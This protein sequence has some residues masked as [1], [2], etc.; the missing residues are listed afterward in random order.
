MSKIAIPNT[1]PDVSK[2]LDT[3]T[4]DPEAGKRISLQ[5]LEQIAAERRENIGWVAM[6]ELNRRAPMRAQQVIAGSVTQ[7]T[8]NEYL[9]R[10]MEDNEPMRKML[11]LGIAKCF[12]ETSDSGL[13]QIILQE[14]CNQYG[15]TGEEAEQVATGQIGLRELLYPFLLRPVPED[16]GEFHIQELVN[17]PDDN[18]TAG[19]VTGWLY[20]K[21]G[22]LSH[23]AIAGHANEPIC[24]QISASL[25][26]A[27]LEYPG[28][29]PDEALLVPGAFLLPVSRM[30]GKEFSQSIVELT[31]QLA[32]LQEATGLVTVHQANDSG[33]E[34][35]KEK[36]K[37]KIERTRKSGQPTLIWHQTSERKG[38]LVYTPFYRLKDARMTPL[39]FELELSIFNSEEFGKLLDAQRLELRHELVRDA[40]RRKHIYEEWKERDTA[41]LHQMARDGFEKL[42]KKGNFKQTIA[43]AEEYVGL[44]LK[45]QPENPPEFWM[46][47]PPQVRSMLIAG[48]TQRL[49]NF[50]ENKLHQLLANDEAWT[51]MVKP[52][53]SRDLPVQGRRNYEDATVGDSDELSY[54]SRQEA[55]EWNL[56]SLIRADEHFIAE[57]D[58]LLKK[59]D[60]K[61]PQR[62]KR[63]DELNLYTL[64]DAFLRNWPPV[65]L[66]DRDAREL[67]K[68]WSE[69]LS[70]V[71]WQEIYE[72][73][74][75]LSIRIDPLQSENIVFSIRG[76]GTRD[77]KLRIT[78]YYLTT[79]REMMILIHPRMGI[80]Y[81]INGWQHRQP[82]KQAHVP[83]GK[84]RTA[85][86]KE[87]CRKGREKLDQADVSHAIE[88][89]Q[90]ALCLQPAV[91]AMELF[92]HF[93][94]ATSTKTS[95]EMKEYLDL[96]QAT[97]E[98]DK[99]REAAL[100]KINHFVTIYPNFL[101]DPY[102][103]RGYNQAE[104]R[105]SVPKL[106]RQFE[107][108]VEHYNSLINRL[109]SM[110]D[111]YNAQA[112]DLINMQQRH[113]ALLEELIKDE[114]LIRDRN[115]QY[116]VDPDAAYRSNR[117]IASP[118]DDQ[119]QVELNDDF[120]F[121]GGWLNKSFSKNKLEE[122]LYLQAAIEAEQEINGPEL[123]KK[124]DELDQMAK[125]LEPLHQRITERREAWQEECSKVWNKLP[126]NLNDDL[127]IAAALAPEYF[128]SACQQGMYKPSPVF[129]SH[130]A[131]LHNLFKGSEYLKITSRLYQEATAK[132]KGLVS[133]L[134]TAHRS[135]K[136]K[137]VLQKLRQLLIECQ[138][139]KYVEEQ[140]ISG[141]ASLQESL[142]Q[143]Q[144][145]DTLA[146]EL[147]IRHRLEDIQGD[148]NYRAYRMYDA[149]ASHIPEVTE[150]RQQLSICQF[151]FCHYKRA[152]HSVIG[153]DEMPL[154]NSYPG[155]SYSVIDVNPINIQSVKIHLSSKTIGVQTAH[156]EYKA[157]L[158]F[159]QLSPE[160]IQ[161]LQTEFAKPG[162]VEK[163]RSSGLVPAYAILYT[164]IGLPEVTRQWRTA[165]SE[166]EAW[167]IRIFAY[168]GIPPSRA[169][170]LETEKAFTHFDDTEVI[171]RV[172][173]DWDE[174]KQEFIQQY[175]VKE[176]VQE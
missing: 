87:L 104:Q 71:V 110:Q 158:Q 90:Q 54:I 150:V 20:R 67:Y 79:D 160:L 23:I 76:T 37:E 50:L 163:L 113:S 80:P 27:M 108:E 157:V 120:L 7:K 89:F 129:L 86:C 1:Y 31:T 99:E 172:E 115:G 139:T 53:T 21:N 29:M 145:V 26:N 47:L 96:V 92:D 124:R 56:P 127:L 73:L 51:E 97:M 107:Q 122:L 18:I 130:V 10:F 101:P 52:L 165:L 114:V 105:S 174:I 13:K 5:L 119:F 111:D 85:L 40:Q 83:K 62:E 154:K 35:E 48:R 78:P 140:E 33:Y 45:E 161:H 36:I 44:L 70:K 75:R 81:Y 152:I 125:E 149:A 68:K 128:Q 109:K 176:V 49:Q 43:L 116:R 4:A 151:L 11:G 25:Y 60:E 24:K 61:D 138:S 136:Q 102:L 69:K 173:I 42:L 59:F 12:K 9:Y 175:K 39:Q 159:E 103:L 131:P 15:L 57:M 58:K 17:E 8:L 41:Q 144:E 156:D 137:E 164:P 6:E 64:L 22:Q 14:L 148:Y 162:Y 16:E 32:Q 95:Q 63:I 141:L 118:T 55:L 112:R 121:S 167:L 2:M 84:G 133:E 135:T 72:N 93:W 153:Q 66:P 155:A 82:K 74:R 65:F 34:D 88:L 126:G 168:V 106:K 3:T 170:F 19:H 132:E 77:E 38:C 98:F 147:M 94:V 46:G 142:E 100:S 117:N 146:R 91:A 143:F 123:Q 171:E 134:K 28:A 166:L 169:D 30:Q